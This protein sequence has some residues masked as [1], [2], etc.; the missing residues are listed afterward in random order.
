M[1]SG[2][3]AAA[4]PALKVVGKRLARIDARERVTGAARYPADLA[5]AGMA[6]GK[7]KRSP[8]AHARIRG[9]D[10]AR[11]AALKG[12]LAVVTAA[13]FPEVALGA[14]V[15]AGE[16]GYDMWMVAQLNIARHKVFWVGQPVAAVAAV[17][18]HVAEAALQLIEVDYEVLPAVLDIKAAMAADAPVLH[19]HVVTKNI[20]PRP[21]APSNVGSR[22]VIGRGDAQAAL[23]SA[24]ATARISVQ[25]DTAHQGYLEPQ[26]V[27]AEVDANGVATVWAS[28]QGQFTAELMIAAMLG[29]PT[30]RLKVVPL[31]IG[32]G[33]G[34]KILIHG[35]AVAVRLAQK[36][37]RAVKLV[38]S[39]EEVLQGGSGPAAAALFDIAVG[40]EK[41]GKLIA[42]DGTY[43]LDAGGL[44]GMSP[45]LVM[46]A[47]A[48]LYQTPNLNL[49]GYDIV[50]NK[51]RTEAYR[52]PVGIQAAFAMEQAM[53]LLSETLG[54]DPLAFRM[55][56]AA[57]TG[58]TM[59]IGTPFPVIGLTTILERVREHACWRDPLPEGRNPRGR[60]LALGYWRGTSMTSAGHITIAGDGRPMVTMG[61]VDLSGTRTT[62]AQVVAEEFGLDIKD[63]HIQVGDTK[64][65]GY[66]DGAAGSRVART[67]TAALVEASRDALAQLRKR[68]AEKLQCA[69]DELDYAGGAFRART[70][71]TISLAE[72][73]HATLTEGAI[74]GRGVSTKLPLGV[75]IGAHVCD[76]E[77]DPATGLV[78]VLRYT[79]FQDVGRALNPAAVEGQIEGSVV[80]GLGWALSEGFD[81]APDGRLRNASLLDYR[82]PTALDVPKIDC[83]IVETPVPNV[84]Y[85]VR[86]VGEVPI[87]P[88]AAAVANA[89]A[90]ATGVR[91]TRMPM[92]PERVL[93]ALEGARA[94]LRVANG[95]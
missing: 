78:T 14:S 86:G 72:L 57:V 34:G 54:M 33:F 59:P 83:V 19:E 1:E 93:A 29:L 45:S 62:M 26:A 75:E 69:G 16:V 47:S 90:R 20:E 30:S 87:V 70:G 7:L 31:E 58:S 65:V 71:A 6:H 85:G 11:A 51:P 21:R 4:A 27:V 91:M 12:V 15:P 50:T 61:A 94:K 89:I 13:D 44:P 32:G 92:T 3:G 77:V 2:Q 63:I 66:S 76:V 80:Q 22:T 8:H 56:N 23:A 39:R 37:R 38:L 5:L 40:A 35:E 36:C 49:Q 53:D 68:A 67:M 74:V 81:Y 52:A 64:S 60:G 17:D 79:A 9:I 82:M 46:Q 88:P 55:R 24:A 48:A 84:P 28:T 42:I 95:E 73:M 43:R 10:T 41:D 25:V 18:P